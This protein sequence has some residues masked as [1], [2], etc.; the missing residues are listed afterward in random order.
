MIASIELN[1]ATL[2]PINERAQRGQQPMKAKMKLGQRLPNGARV[3]ICP[4][5]GK[6]GAIEIGMFE[7][8]MGISIDHSASHHEL[9]RSDPLNVQEAALLCGVRPV[10]IYTAV[11]RSTLRAKP[12]QSGWPITFNPIDFAAYFNTPDRRRKE[13]D[14]SEPPTPTRAAQVARG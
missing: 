14:T 7:T 4:R 1:G 13:E 11:H 9:M 10:T 6:I 12:R 3:G 5:C 2:A 8:G